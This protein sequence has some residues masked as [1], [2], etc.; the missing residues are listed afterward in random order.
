MARKDFKL[1]L[2]CENPKFQRAVLRNI[3]KIY[4][5]SGARNAKQLFERLR[6]NEYSL[7]IVDYRLS[8]LRPEETD[9]K[10]AR[11]CPNVMFVVYSAAE[12]KSAAE[13]LHKFRALDYLIHTP[14]IPDFA[15][16]IHKAVRWTILQTEVRSL[17][18]KISK[19]AETIRTLSKRIEKV[20]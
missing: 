4:S 11:F 6:H 10:I 8:G 16:K 12:R 19:V 9:Q 14:K 13:K 2:A 7:V 20:L 17:S 15:E 3:S 1:L 5:V 18:S